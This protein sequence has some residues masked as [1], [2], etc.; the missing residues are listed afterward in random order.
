M[1]RVNGEDC[2][3]MAAVFVQLRCDTRQ[4]GQLYA[5]WRDGSRVVRERLLAE[6][7]L[8]LKTQLQAP[9]CREMSALERK[10]LPRVRH[11]PQRIKRLQAY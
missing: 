6:P 1:A 3:R 10:R 5:A 8:F 11:K 9:E 7:E 4:A 2:A